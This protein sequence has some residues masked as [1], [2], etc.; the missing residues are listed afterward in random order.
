MD[1]FSVSSN[2]NI[3]NMVYEKCPMGDVGTDR[4]AKASKH[5]PSD[6]DTHS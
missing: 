1:E 4:S 6:L 5:S 3:D 2:L